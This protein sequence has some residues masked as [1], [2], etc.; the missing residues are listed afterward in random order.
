MP[1][2][3]LLFN[4]QRQYQPGSKSEPNV[5]VES[6]Y[7]F[8][9]AFGAEGELSPSLKTRLPMTIKLALA[10]VEWLLGGTLATEKLFLALGRSPRFRCGY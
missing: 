3:T 1:L 7:D 2:A 10:Q 5:K 8:R 9:R 6:G 4:N